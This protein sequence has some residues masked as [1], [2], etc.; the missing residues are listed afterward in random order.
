[1][2]AGTDAPGSLDTRRRRGGSC[3]MSVALRCRTRPDGA[4]TVGSRT[5]GG[6]R[7]SD[8]PLSY[9]TA[10]RKASSRAVAWAS[11]RA[12][13]P[14]SWG[15]PRLAQQARSDRLQTEV[16]PA[17]Q[18]QGAEPPA[19]ELLPQPTELGREEG[20]V[21][22]GVMGHG[23]GVVETPEQVPGDVAEGGSVPHVGV[24][25]AVYATTCHRAGGVDQSGPLVRDRAEIVDGDDGDLR[26]LVPARAQARRLEVH[27]CEHPVTSALPAS[28][29]HGP[30]QRRTT[31]R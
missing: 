27:Q 31:T 30:R 10:D 12:L 1:M 2:S 20:R 8:T 22:P 7:W 21:E 19:R 6:G 23:H 13:W 18:L 17:C 11:T 25:D 16:E 15:T 3:P 5:S 24:E 4:R 14:S 29:G 28:L 9:A 26:D